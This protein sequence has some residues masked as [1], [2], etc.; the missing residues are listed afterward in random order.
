[1]DVLVAVGR[2]MLA[3]KE[4]KKQ[5]GVFRSHDARCS[6][7]KGRFEPFLNIFSYHMLRF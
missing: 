5:G 1:M 4:G 7:L 6:V 3:S 2:K